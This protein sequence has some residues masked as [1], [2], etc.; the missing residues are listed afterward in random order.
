MITTSSFSDSLK[1]NTD[2][3]NEV[4][5]DVASVE[6]QLVFFFNKNTIAIKPEDISACHPI[7][8]KPMRDIVVRLVSRKT[9]NMIL[10]KAKKEKC[11]KGT[12]DYVGEHLTKKIKS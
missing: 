6:N 7:G 2:K 8:K 5:H 1:L 9:T 12:D 11:H 10:Y 4:T 3:E